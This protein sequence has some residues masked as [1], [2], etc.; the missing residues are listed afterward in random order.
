MKVLFGVYRRGYR[1][2]RDL[3]RTN[4]T[5]IDI[6][7]T[8][9]AFNRFLPLLLRLRRDNVESRQN[10]LQMDKLSAIRAVS[11]KFV[12]NCQEAYTPYD[13]MAIDE[14]LKSIRGLLHFT[15]TIQISLPSMNSKSRQW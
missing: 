6:F 4:S 12:T 11:D 10:G 5:R 2:L 14:K 7:R 1:H 8:V 9:M 13:H 3:W 15:N